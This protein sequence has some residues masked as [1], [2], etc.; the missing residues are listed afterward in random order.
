MPRQS[1]LA[2]LQSNH[3]TIQRYTV[4]TTD[5]FVLE[6]IILSDNYRSLLPV[7]NLPL[8]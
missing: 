2:S 7:A 3:V 5:R 4:C 8:V 6:A 1:T